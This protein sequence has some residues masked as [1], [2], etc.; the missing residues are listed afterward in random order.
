MTEQIP[1]TGDKNEIV[2]KKNELDN[3]KTIINTFSEKTE[4]GITDIINNNFLSLSVQ[5]KAILREM[6]QAERAIS[7]AIKYMWTMMK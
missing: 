5:D 3:V 6:A 1:I 7:I 2:L 4:T